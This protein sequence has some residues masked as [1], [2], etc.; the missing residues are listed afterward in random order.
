LGYHVQLHNCNDVFIYF[1]GNVII[2]YGN[3]LWLISDACSV[4]ASVFIVSTAS[5]LI[6]YKGYVNDTSNYLIMILAQVV[7]GFLIS[8]SLQDLLYLLLMRTHIVHL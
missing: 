8:I 3:V 7:A 2:S 4:A 5:S 1:K 6:E